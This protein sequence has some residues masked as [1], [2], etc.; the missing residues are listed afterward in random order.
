M[1]KNKIIIGVFSFILFAFLSFFIFYI[2]IL[3]ICVS[4]VKVINC[5]ENF[6]KK[7]LKCEI[8]IEKPKLKTEFSSKIDFQVD[9][10]FISKDNKNI[11]SF[12]YINQYYN[13]TPNSSRMMEYRISYLLITS[14]D[15][16][17]RSKNCFRLYFIISIR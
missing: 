7:Y 11:L 1:K 14:G 4:N 5:V 16:S 8:E 6:A 9:S 12:S 13:S 15:P 10:F 3:P 17:Q 2:K